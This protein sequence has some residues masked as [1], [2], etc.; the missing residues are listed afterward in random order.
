MLKLLRSTSIPRSALPAPRSFLRGEDG[1]VSVM[2]LI[3]FGIMIIFAGVAI[4]FMRSEQERIT[5]QATIDR[6]VLAA[7]PLDESRDAREVVESYLRAADIDPDTVRIQSYDEPHA[8][9]VTAHGEASVDSMFLDLF[10]MNVM[11]ASVAGQAQEAKWDLEVSLVL[12][13]SGSMWNDNGTVLDENQKLTKLK[14]AAVDFARELFDT[15]AA[16]GTLTTIT[17]IPYNG[18]VNAG[19][20]VGSWFELSDEH[21]FSRCVVWSDPADFEETDITLGLP[22]ERMA[23]YSYAWDD[24]YREWY[25]NWH[26][27]IGNPTCPTDDTAAILPWATTLAEVQT[28]VES[29]TAGGYTAIPLGVKWGAAFLDPSMQPQMDAMVA[30]GAVSSGYTAF[31]SEFDATG[32][33]KVLVVMTDG[34]NTKQMDIEADRK[35]GPSGVFVYRSG[36]SV[37]VRSVEASYD[38]NGDGTIDALD[39][40]CTNGLGSLDGVTCGTDGDGNPTFPSHGIDNIDGSSNW[41]TSWHAGRARGQDWV[42]NGGRYTGYAWWEDADRRN[43]TAFDERGSGDWRD[44]TIYPQYSI[45]S[46]TEQKFWVKNIRTGNGWHYAS[47]GYWADEPAGGV[48]AIELTF[49]ELYA[50][51]PTWHD[52]FT[53]ARPNADGTISST[54]VALDSESRAWYF[55]NY[56]DGVDET[57]SYAHPMVE[58]MATELDDNLSTICETARSAGIIVYT[59]A[60]QAPDAGVDAMEDCAGLSNPGNAW[61]ITDL[62]IAEAFDGILAN[63]TKLKLTQ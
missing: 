18:K 40:P 6:A 41:S 49:A 27:A 57:Y 25:N 24:T 21:S 22:L 10:G 15:A 59:I 47:G 60:F 3:L 26:G 39:L 7:A 54:K 35:D 29:F 32:V 20:E 5:M 38:H 9:R 53:T 13:V 19:S 34:A 4:D 48:D 52:R 43:W 1:S 8:T 2:G 46:E 62:D 63:L 58:D 30:S 50:A 33:R 42:G 11:Q 56:V 16:D 31:P 14:T 55:G 28:H 37:P 23:H 12:D 61:N 17:V 45:W 51:I 36:L 44:P